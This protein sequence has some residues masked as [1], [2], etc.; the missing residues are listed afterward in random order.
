MGNNPFP[1]LELLNAIV[2]SSKFFYGSY[3]F[4]F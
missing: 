4:M 2:F 3:K 1:F